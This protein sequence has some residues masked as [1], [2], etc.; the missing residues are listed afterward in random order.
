[1]GTWALGSGG[2]LIGKVFK[3]YIRLT[4]GAPNSYFPV[5][6]SANATA[7][8]NKHNISQTSHPTVPRPQRYCSC[9]SNMKTDIIIYK[10]LGGHRVAEVVRGYGGPPPKSLDLDENF[11][12]KHTLFCHR[13]RFDAIYTLFGDL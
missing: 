5:H 10:F 8:A 12:P 3:C 7:G 2:C 9:S 4:L 1:M 11:K 6:R 13:L